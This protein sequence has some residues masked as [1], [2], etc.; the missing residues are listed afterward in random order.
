VPD[1]VRDSIDVRLE[2]IGAAR[3]GG[4]EDSE[5]GS[6]SDAVRNY[7]V[8]LVTMPFSFVSGPSIQIGLLKAIARQA[9]FP[10]DDHYLNL[11]LAAQLGDAAYAKIMDNQ[12]G[13]LTGEWLFSVA[14][15]GARASRADYFGAFPE[16]A[17]RVTG[18]SGKGVEFW[19]DLRERV[20]PAYIED[21]LDKTDWGSY[22]AVGFSSAY[23]QN[24]AS[25]A[26]ARR[27]K[28][29]FPHVAI[30]FGGP[31]M[32]GE[33]GL[34]YVRAFPYV[35]YAVSGEG[36]L[37]FPALLTRLAE[38]KCTE[39]LAGVITRR[40]DTVT[41]TGPAEP[42]TDLDSL[43]I[44]DYDAFFETAH[45]YGLDDDRSYKKARMRLLQSDVLPIEGSRGCWWGEK[46]HCTFCGLYRGS[47]SYRSKS[48]ERMLA[49]LDDLS[50]KYNK[51]AFF[52]CDSIL[53]MKFIDGV[54]APLAARKAGY[55]F[56]YF[57]KANLTR[58]QIRTLAKGGMRF[59]FPG[60]ESLSSH[61]LRLMRKGTTKLQNV[62]FLRWS[63]YYD[64]D[65]G[66]NLLYGF[67]G[68]LQ[69]DY[70]EE[71]ETIRLISHLAPPQGAYP[72]TLHRFSPDFC[73]EERFPVP[74][75]R[76][77]DSYSYVYPD[78]VNLNEAAF[79][80]DCDLG[81]DEALADLHRQ[82]SELIATWFGGWY[83]GGRASLTYRRCGSELM[84]EDT[85]FDRTARYTLIEQDADIYEAF[86]AAPRS[87]AQVYASLSSELGP[88]APDEETVRG[89]C[90]VFCDMGL[91]IEDAGKYL[92]LA[93]PADPECDREQSEE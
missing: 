39:D 20:L 22:N 61:V 29:S 30:I 65:V 81:C 83:D 88:M 43:P 85:R 46:S 74:L 21:C 87:P 73:D 66:W 67:P 27:I 78:D 18:A 44:P 15:F 91:M 40:G 57:T 64:I 16:E 38:G 62:N 92:S 68:E 12:N 23:Q 45:A 35:D 33:M 89:A 47:I 51:K 50:A 76:P 4:K 80:F 7:R 77:D 6:T 82:A 84:V 56:F 60:I 10:V 24:V 13:R 90:D 36:D 55:E 32:D 52:P 79:C 59:I 34:E 17:A 58:S 14:A 71:L 5:A 69:E 93:I 41:F 1:T 70:A 8:A 9:G 54:F 28:A 19:N 25:L 37:A 49:E 11:S 53:N 2:G 31:N 48:P 3:C 63:T 42:I 75:R 26:L 86:G 72:I